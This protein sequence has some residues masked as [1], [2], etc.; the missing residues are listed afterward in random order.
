MAGVNQH[1]AEQ[2]LANPSPQIRAEYAFGL[3]RAPA[4]SAMGLLGRAYEFETEAVVRRAIIAAAS[5][6]NEH[7]RQRLIDLASRLD[8]DTQVRQLARLA[9]SGHRLSSAARAGQTFWLVLGNNAPRK[10]PA[11][12][13][14]PVVVQSTRGQTLVAFADPDGFIGLT[15]MDAGAVSYVLAEPAR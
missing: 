12:D 6:R 1:L 7:P 13:R 14:Q 11:L 5:L 4:P 15:G 10:P 9:R 2:L 3:G 8:P